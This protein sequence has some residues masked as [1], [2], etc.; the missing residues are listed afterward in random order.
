[1][2]KISHSPIPTHATGQAGSRRAFGAECV[3]AAAHVAR[4]GTI[5]IITR[6]TIKT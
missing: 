5:V 6:K 1:M 2:V 4:I 3:I